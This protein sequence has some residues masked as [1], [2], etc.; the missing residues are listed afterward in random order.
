MHARHGSFTCFISRLG[1]AV[2]LQFLFITDEV[3]LAIHWDI[4]RRDVG[5]RRFLLGFRSYA[6][7]FCSHR[8]CRRC[9]RNLP[10]V[11]RRG[12]GRTG[13]LVARLRRGFCR[14]TG[15][16]RCGICTRDIFR[17]ACLR[18]GSNSLS[19]FLD[20]ELSNVT[21]EARF[22]VA[23]LRVLAMVRFLPTRRNSV[24]CFDMIPRPIHSFMTFP[25]HSIQS[26]PQTRPSVLPLGRKFVLRSVVRMVPVS[27]VC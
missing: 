9:R 19:R 27:G 25:V 7:R 15:C 23:L 26:I 17:L 12:L 14:W 16:F 4:G 20:M 18:R 21:H 13:Y 1:H 3:T 5:S 8:R 24:C 6:T 11:C 10:R 2:A 22:R